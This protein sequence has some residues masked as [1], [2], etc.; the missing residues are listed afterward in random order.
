MGTR[1]PVAFWELGAWKQGCVNRASAVVHIGGWLGIDGALRA[2]EVFL[3]L[4]LSLSYVSW[5]L[6]HT[7]LKGFSFLLCHGAPSVTFF[8]LTGGCAHMSRRSRLTSRLSDVTADEVLCVR[9]ASLVV[10]CSARALPTAARSL[11]RGLPWCLLVLTCWY[12]SS[13]SPLAR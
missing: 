13:R 4:S 2:G 5:W 9:G 3:S 11:S 8:C 1:K 10:L 7:G 6:G 12:R